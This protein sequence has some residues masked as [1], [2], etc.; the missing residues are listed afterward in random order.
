[1]LI[2]TPIRI[3][4]HARI[5]MQKRSITKDEVFETLLTPEKTYTSQNDRCFV[6]GRLCVVVAEN[7]SS[8]TVKT[9]LL[10]ED[11][12]WTDKDVRNRK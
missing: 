4:D 11:K 9:V 10:S 6:K 7:Q 12:Q 8:S 1:M 3:S 5:N 2:K